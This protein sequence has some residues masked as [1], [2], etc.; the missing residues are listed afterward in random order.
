[1]KRIYCSTHCWEQIK[2]GKT[3]PSWNGGKCKIDGYIYIYNP[4][5]PFTTK[6]RYVC[7]HRLIMEKSIG[8]FL[9]KNEVVHHINR[10]RDDNRIENLIIMTDSKHKSFHIR[11][12]NNK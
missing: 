5:H 8:R 10:I 6:G 7:E 11:E 4:R 12:N 1:M 2:K 9:T 3:H